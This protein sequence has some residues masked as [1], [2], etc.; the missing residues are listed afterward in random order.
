MSAYFWPWS[1]W[2]RCLIQ[3]QFEVC[4]TNTEFLPLLRKTSNTSGTVF[5]VT[6][7]CRPWRVAK[8]KLAGPRL[9]DWLCAWDVVF[10]SPA[11][12]CCSWWTAR[13]SCCLPTG[14]RRGPAWTSCRGSCSSCPLS[15]RTWSLWWQ[16]WVSVACV[17]EQF[18]S[19][20][21]I[22]QF[23]AI[24]LKIIVHSYCYIEMYSFLKFT[25]NA[26]CL[27]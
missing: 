8:D 1:L 6:A 24:A 11:G 10:L 27:Q 23:S 5:S 4:C 7:I 15:C 17:W 16:A 13:W 19:P 22:H 26:F 14:R 18:Q 12:L 25:T 9:V 20:P 21:R 3:E 2:V